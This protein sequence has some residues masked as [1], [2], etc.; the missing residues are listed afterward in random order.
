MKIYF[1]LRKIYIENIKFKVKTKFNSPDCTKVK[2]TLN[3]EKITETCRQK[4]I[5][6]HIFI[7]VD[8]LMALQ[9]HLVTQ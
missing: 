9:L 4:I 5:K 1:Y 6:N 8:L 2:L 3:I 7:F